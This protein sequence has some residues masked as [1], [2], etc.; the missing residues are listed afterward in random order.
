MPTLEFT[1]TEEKLV[2]AALPAERARKLLL[3]S[4][5]EED[6]ASLRRIVDGREWQLR[7]VKTCRDAFQWLET[8]PISVVFCDQVLEDGSWKDILQ[9]LANRAEGPLLVVVSR[10]ADDYLWSEVL[11]LGGYDVL[12]KPFNSR[13]VTHV[14]TT[15]S[16]QRMKHKGDAHIAGAA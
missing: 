12:A 15:I 3:I 11:N 7:S 2:R 1:P 10:Q 8:E 16:L 6:R 5:D 13:E 4:P 9:R 14:L